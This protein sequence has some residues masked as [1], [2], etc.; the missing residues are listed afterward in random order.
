M[1]IQPIKK[2][3]QNLESKGHKDKYIKEKQDL[4][5]EIW[6]CLKATNS[7]NKE[8]PFFL[9]LRRFNSYTPALPPRPRL[10]ISGK[11]TKDNL[12]WFAR[13]R[14]LIYLGD[15][16]HR[17]FTDLKGGGCFLSWEGKGI[18]IDPGY[19]FI[20][21][22]YSEELAI[23]DI[24]AIIVTHAH[25]DHYIDLV[26]ILTLS[27]QYNKLSNAYHKMNAKQWKGAIKDLD[28]LLDEQFYTFAHDARLYCL[29]QDARLKDTGLSKDKAQRIIHNFEAKLNQHILPEI[30]KRY[31]LKKKKIKLF[32]SESAKASLSQ[33][34]ETRD[35]NGNTAYLADVKKPFNLDDIKPELSIPVK[36]TDT[37]H[38]DFKRITG[39]GLK[40][41]LHDFILGIT[42]DTGWFD[43]GDKMFNE[44]KPFL[45]EI[46]HYF[47]NCNMLVP[48]IGSIKRK[49][50]DWLQLKGDP[51]KKQQFRSCL[52]KTHLG[53]LG[54]L[55]LVTDIKQ[56][57][58]KLQLVAIT[59]FGEE[60]KHIRH[61][62]AKE[63]DN[64]AA[65]NSRTKY[66]A[67]DIGL[68]IR[69]P[70][71]HT[72]RLTIR[73]G[74]R[75]PRTGKE[76]YEEPKNVQQKIDRLTGR[77]TYETKQLRT[78]P[79]TLGEKITPDTEQ[80]PL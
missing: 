38:N 48:H 41:T 65:L 80:Y 36:T 45:H 79:R 40:F 1:N 54:L 43:T 21:N 2:I 66:L 44:Q 30:D 52:Y 22:M 37:K 58:N 31:P 19:D 7:I 62:L 67:A 78:H 59:E 18:V 74:R 3:L 15:N 47:D 28:D 14:E 32:F 42:S 70:Y 63:M 75:D 4:D 72:Q 12:D 64:C 49:E 53:I 34:L 13:W 24:D 35:A 77:I 20:E 26:S 57:R 6:D 33:I 17:F 76:K 50:L 56:S 8:E 39:N 10:T 73:V 25:N 23:G 68:K 27:Y 9:F 11:P 61:Y 16:N 29:K 69:L 71:K 60:M 51:E 55:R 46:S 5:Q